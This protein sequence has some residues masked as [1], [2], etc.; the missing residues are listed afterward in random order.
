VDLPDLQ[1]TVFKPSASS[2][3]PSVAASPRNA[4]PSKAQEVTMARWNNF[5]REAPPSTKR[6][7]MM[8]LLVGGAVAMTVALLVL[9][10][11]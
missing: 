9:K 11:L 4:L 1:G 6:P 10:L 7:I 5:P 2:R 3:L 8:L